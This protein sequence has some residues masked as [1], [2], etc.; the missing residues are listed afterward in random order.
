MLIFTYTLTGC[1][2]ILIVPIKNSTKDWSK[3]ILFTHTRANDTLARYVVFG[4]GDKGF[5]LNTP[6]WSDLKAS[7]AFCAAFHL[8][9]SA[10][11][12]KF[13]NAVREDD[14][15][16]KVSLSKEDYKKLVQYI[17]SS[18]VYDASNKVQWIANHSYGDYDAFYEANGKYSL[19]YTC[20]TWTNN[21]LKA[22]NQKAAL[23]TPYDKGVLCHY[24]E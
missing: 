12:T 18:F 11:H 8:G 17:S 7:T 20:N 13:Y 19:F 2:L 24:N 16:I 21:A 4:W 3:D 15:C 6:Q 1:I 10:M 23:W 22:A 5:Y 14:E 9:T